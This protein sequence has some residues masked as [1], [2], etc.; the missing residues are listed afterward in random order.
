MQSERAGLG[1]IVRTMSP[2]DQTEF[3][4]APGTKLGVTVPVAIALL[5]VTTIGAV[6]PTPTA[7]S[8]GTVETICGG[9]HAARNEEEFGTGPAINGFPSTSLPEIVTEYIVH[10]R[11]ITE[12]LTMTVRFP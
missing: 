12:W 2:L 1:V 4:V 8:R 7:P 11:N 5:N 10:S 3:T 9:V 6:E